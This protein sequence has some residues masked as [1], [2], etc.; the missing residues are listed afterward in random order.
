MGVEISFTLA[1]GQLQ[2]I[3]VDAT[4]RELHEASA[5]VTEHPIEVGANVSDH[6]RANLDSVT[7]D[8]VVSNEPIR[9]PE[10][11]MDGVTSRQQGLEIRDPTTGIILAKANVLVFDGD[12]DR[13]RTVYEELLRLR[14]TGTV[15]GIL[16]SLRE[17]SSMVIRRVAPIREA[18]TGDS[19][20]ATVEARQIRIVSSEVVDVP[21]PEETRGDTNRNRGRRNNEDTDAETDERNQSIAR[22]ILDSI[23][24]WAG[25]GESVPPPPP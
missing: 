2:S 21:E 10:S 4:V 7:L 6:I 16:T 17:Y 12:F 9:Q 24:S 25:G 3:I 13:V 15:V 14:T 19:L 11:Q 1:D 23:A 18:A 22:G 5:E 20:R 8:V